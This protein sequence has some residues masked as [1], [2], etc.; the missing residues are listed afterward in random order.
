MK[1]LILYCLIAVSAALAVSGCGVAGKTS[2]EDALYA[3]SVQKALA[4]KDYTV[5]I[6]FMI[7]SVGASRNVSNYSI[8]VNGDTFVS[9]LPYQGRAYNLPY[10]GGQGF[11]FTAEIDEYQDV[12]Q[13]NGNHEITIRLHNDEDT[14]VYLLSVSP[15]GNAYLKV[16]SRNRENISYSGQ[17]DLH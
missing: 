17:L 4:G 14:F 7:P 3:E 15:D 6:Q 13:K 8:K 1:R 12:V 11:D 10:G 16:T 2:A 5:A 9:Y